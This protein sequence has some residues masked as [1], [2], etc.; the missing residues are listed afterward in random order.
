MATHSSVLAWRISGTGEPGGL[1]SLR[2]HR[3]GYDW[4]DL[5]AAAAAEKAG[6]PGISGILITYFQHPLGFFCTSPHSL[7]SEQSR[8]GLSERQGPWAP[9]FYQPPFCSQ[10]FSGFSPE[11]G[12]FHVLSVHYH[13][14]KVISPWKNMIPQLRPGPYNLRRST[15]GWR[16]EGGCRHTHSHTDIQ[17]RLFPGVCV[18]AHRHSA[19]AFIHRHRLISRAQV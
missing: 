8:S 13:S 4:S 19:R 18:N 12:S 10:L 7:K 6:I 5:A 14:D 3:V 15:N 11:P 16:P 1:P 17:L 9:K 2:S